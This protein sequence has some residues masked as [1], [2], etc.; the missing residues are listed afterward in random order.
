M[1]GD[2]D[3]DCNVN[4]E[5]FAAFALAWLSELGDAEWRLDCEISQPPDGVI[6]G[7]DLGAFVENWLM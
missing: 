1:D 5:D 2:I 3:T 7:F 6:D 4:F